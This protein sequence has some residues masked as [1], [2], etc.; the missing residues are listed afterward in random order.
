MTKSSPVV[1]KPG[2]PSAWTNLEIPDGHVTVI[3]AERE[4]CR[5][6]PD[7]DPR[8]FCRRGLGSK[9]SGAVPWILLLASFPGTSR[10]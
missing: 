1:P 2:G 3:L 9:A 10:P 4:Q 6:M 8:R 5:D 7:D